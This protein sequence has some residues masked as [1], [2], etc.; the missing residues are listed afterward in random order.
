MNLNSLS[1]KELL[2]KTKSLVTSEREVLT[3]ILRHLQEIQ[4]RRLYSALGFPSLFS[5]C[6]QALKYSESQAQRRIVAMRMITEIPTIEEKI[7]R[8]ELSLSNVVQAKTFFNQEEKLSAMSPHEKFKVLEELSNKS[9]REGEK[10][11]ISRSSVPP[12]PVVEKFR[13]VTPEVTEVRFSADQNLLSKMNRIKGLIA[14]R[15]PGLNTS[16]L[17]NELCEMALNELDPLRRELKIGKKQK[18]DLPKNIPPAPKVAVIT[19]TKPTR[20]YISIKLKK[21]VWRKAAGKCQ[22]CSSEYALEIDHLNPLSLGGSSDIKNLRLL[23]RHCNQRAAI[24]RLGYN[25]M[26]RYLE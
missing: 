5:Y 7:S 1:D 16:D 25:Q 18:I 3:E 4:R 21:D 17:I 9:S 26:Q 13:Q 15:K 20:Q 22:N 10:I 19:T 24:A 12:K 23:C 6:M 8:G 2:E 14:H 11:L